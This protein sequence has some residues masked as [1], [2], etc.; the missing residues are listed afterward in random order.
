VDV[1]TNFFVGV[2]DALLG[3]DV[4]AGGYGADGRPGL[5]L[6]FGV[7][8]VVAGSPRLRQ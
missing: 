5:A 1:K 8:A 2:P 4:A 6:A 3:S 7:E